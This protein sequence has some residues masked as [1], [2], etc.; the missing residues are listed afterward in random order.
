M[1]AIRAVAILD[2]C[3]E[4][5]QRNNSGGSVCWEAGMI[6]IHNDVVVA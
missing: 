3:A 1:D 2:I 5:V 6:Y 4:Y